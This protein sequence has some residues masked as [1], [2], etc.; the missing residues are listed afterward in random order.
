[1]GLGDTIPHMGGNQW[2]EGQTIPYGRGGRSWGAPWPCPTSP[3]PARRRPIPCPTPPVCHPP[4]RGSEP[5]APQNTLQ[6]LYSRLLRAGGSARLGP[7]GSSQGGPRPR[8]RPGVPSPAPAAGWA[9]SPWGGEGGRGRG[10]RRVPARWPSMAQ[11][12]PAWPSMARHMA[13]GRRS[14]GSG[15]GAAGGHRRSCGGQEGPGG[16]CPVPANWCPAGRWASG[17]RCRWGARA[18]RRSRRV[19]ALGRKNEVS[20]PGVVALGTAGRAGGG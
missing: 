7:G 2:G 6:P 19:A 13:H 1:M 3:P 12:G 15:R 4:Q 9:R 17:A 20:A 8:Q 11:H 18:P 14:A 16:R 10:S 5:P